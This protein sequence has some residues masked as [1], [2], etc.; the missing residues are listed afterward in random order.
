MIVTFD[1]D[2]ENLSNIYGFPPKVILL[3]LG[4]VSTESAM[5]V[6]LKQ[7]ADIEQFFDSDIYGILE[8]F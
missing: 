1:E 8:L 5:T 7:M 6:L 2:F 4:N 3:R